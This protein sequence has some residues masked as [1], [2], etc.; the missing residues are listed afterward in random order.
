MLVRY[1]RGAGTSAA[2]G[3][4]FTDPAVALRCG[5]LAARLGSLCSRP[6]PLRHHHVTSTTPS[7]ELLGGWLQDVT[8]LQ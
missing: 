2:E 3:P 1:N 7:V 8:G 5:F 6:V 4:T